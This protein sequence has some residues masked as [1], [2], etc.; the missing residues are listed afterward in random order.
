VL[1]NSAPVDFK[2]F[3]KQY[4]HLLTH[5]KLHA[6]FYRFHSGTMIDLPFMLIP[7]KDVYKYP[8]PKLIDRY[9]SENLLKQ[10]D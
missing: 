7:L 1:L 8:I 6:R 10:E 3:S 4:I 9:L 2:G 5:Q